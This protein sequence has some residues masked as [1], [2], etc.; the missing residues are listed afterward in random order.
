MTR[1]A[2][3]LLLAQ[4]PTVAPAP[5][6]LPPAAIP[7]DRT[8]NRRPSVRNVPQRLAARPVPD[9]AL[10][11]L[12]ADPAFQY[13]RPVAEQPS[14][15]DRFWRWVWENVLGPFLRASST[16][17]G[18][19]LW[20][21][22]AVA[23]MVAVGLRLFGTG[24]GGLFGRRD[25]APGDAADPLLG[26]TDIGRVDLAALLADALGRRDWRAAVRLRYLVALQRLDARG[27]VA[28][29]RDK[30]NRT[31]VREAAARGGADV[32]RAFG[33]V[34]RA[35]ESVWYGGLAVDSARWARVD[36]RFERLDAAVAAAPIRPRDPA[37]D[38]ARDAVAGGEVPA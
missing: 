37:R 33:D 32:G 4:V 16:R 20:L 11:A 23:V 12:R 8:P 31:L 25:A 5:P 24:V 34:T 17:T 10:A 3:L 6:T 2:L 28:W 21:L 27:L 30:T 22:A 13:D 15:A 26:V 14:L 1:V 19:G 36:A 7:E 9:S 38:P 18:Q 29:G 35:F